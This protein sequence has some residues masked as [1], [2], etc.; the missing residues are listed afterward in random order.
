MELGV[1]KSPTSTLIICDELDESEE[2]EMKTGVF[3]SIE[4][5][6]YCFDCRDIQFESDVCHCSMCGKDFLKNNT[7][8]DELEELKILLVDPRDDCYK[9]AI[10]QG[11]KVIDS[12]SAK[13]PYGLTMRQLGNNINDVFVDVGYNDAEMRAIAKANKW[14]CIKCNPK[15]YDSN[16]GRYFQTI[17]K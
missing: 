1:A 12:G 9:W 11:N 17:F 14:H 13:T 10:V 6:P 8:E 5:C 7:D 15:D 16:I 3:E 2:P 4:V